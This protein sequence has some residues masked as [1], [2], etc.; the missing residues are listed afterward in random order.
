MMATN[1]EQDDTDQAVLA[2]LERLAGAIDGRGFAR[3]ERINFAAMAAERRRRA[4]RRRLAFVLP[5][6]A[7]ACIAI[8]FALSLRPA[9]RP[10]QQELA[11]M[12]S[13]APMVEEFLSSSI[14]ALPA[15]PDSFPG[16]A[17]EAPGLMDVTVPALPSLPSESGLMTIPSVSFPTL[18]E[19]SDRDESS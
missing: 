9:P 5:A 7:A 19:R 14:I 6:A 16:T 3:F 15:A 11:A 8:G 10:A 17:F 4:F 13:S 12:T 18:T 1:V 2:G